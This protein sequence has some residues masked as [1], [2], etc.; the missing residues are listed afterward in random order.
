[1]VELRVPLE[2]EV[3]VDSLLLVQI[4]HR[5]HLDLL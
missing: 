1:M 3:V 2:E 4:L 5:V